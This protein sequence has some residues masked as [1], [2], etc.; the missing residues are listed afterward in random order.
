MFRYDL[1]LRLLL[2]GVLI[3]MLVHLDNGCTE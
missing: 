2:K 1:W 3:K